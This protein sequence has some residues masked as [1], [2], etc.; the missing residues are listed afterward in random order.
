MVRRTEN[1]CRLRPNAS[2]RH[3]PV[4]FD[5]YLISENHFISDTHLEWISLNYRKEKAAAISPSRRRMVLM[6]FQKQFSYFP[7]L[8]EIRDELIEYQSNIMQNES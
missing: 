8:R 1:N 6:M 7:T 4:Q 3:D 2:R 5:V